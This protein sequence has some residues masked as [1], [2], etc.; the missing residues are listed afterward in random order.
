MQLNN[1]WTGLHDNYKSQSGICL[2]NI[3]TVDKWK[4]HISLWSIIFKERK[5][6][7]QKKYL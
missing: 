5:M 6:S 3:E 2:L 7:N 4:T 1:F